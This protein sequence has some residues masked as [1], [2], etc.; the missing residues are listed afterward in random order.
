MARFAKNAFIVLLGVLLVSMFSSV[1]WAQE[2]PAGDIALKAVE[3]VRDLPVSSTVRLLVI[4]TA[5]TFL[6]AMLLAMTPFT[7]FIIVLSMLRQAVGLQQS[8]PNQVLVGLCMFLSL[9]LMRPTL[10]EVYNTALLPFMN[11]ELQPGEAF[12]LA[13]EPMRIFMLSNTRKEDLSTMLEIG[14]LPPP[15]G[16]D[17]IPHSI[18][19]SSFMLS[20]L[21]TAFIIGVKIYLPFL[22]IDVVVAS[23]LLGMGMMVLPPVVLSLPFKILLFV[24]MDGWSLLIRMMASGF[25]GV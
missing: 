4:L 13:M 7:R 16:L 6:P 15:E 21:K 3:E 2:D 19:V 22:V 10:T 20:E 11:G 9:L 17:D 1:A 24:L 25:Y 18:V 12:E 14:Q 5:L 23:I 8:P